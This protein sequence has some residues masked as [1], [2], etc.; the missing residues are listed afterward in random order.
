M[1]NEFF[2]KKKFPV[3]ENE[4]E[5]L[6]ALSSYNIL[7]TFPDEDL[8]S[9]TL[10]AS[11]ICRTPI[12]LISLIDDKRQWFKSRVGFEVKELPREMSICQFTIMQESIY[13][14]PDTTKNS[15]FAENPLVTAKNGIRFY[16]G[17][18]LKDPNGFR[19]GT[20]CV[21][22]RQP[23][24][25]DDEQKESLELLAKEVVTHLLMRKQNDELR[26]SKETL[27]RFFDLTLDFMCIANVNGFFLKI[28]STFSSVLGYNEKELLGKPFLEFVHPDDVEV[29]LKEVEKLSRGELTIQ[30]ENR[31]RQI[32]GNYIWLSWNVKPE[33]ESGLLYATARNITESKLAEELYHKNLL[34]QKEKEIAERSGQMKEEFLANMSHEIRTP[35]NAIIGLSGL[36][37]KKGV[38]RGKEL[39]YIQTINLNSSNLFQ[40]VDNI[41]DFT[42]IESGNFDKRTTEFNIKQVIEDSARSLELT[43][44]EKGLKLLT[45]IGSEVPDAVIGHPEKLGQALLNL[46]SNSIKF[47]SAGEVNVEAKLITLNPNSAVVKFTVSDTGLGIPKEKLEDVFQP[48]V[49]VNSSFTRIHGGTG[50]GLAITRKLVEIQG[51]EIHLQSEVGKGSQFYFTLLFP[52]NEKAKDSKTKGEITELHVAR[53]GMRILIVEDNPF[54]QMVAID[55]LQ[56][57]SSSI[58]TDVAENGK[59]AIEKLKTNKYDLVLMD[60]QMPEM[61]GHTATKIIRNELEESLRYIPIIAMTAHASV[62]EI[63]SCF[64]DGMNEYISKPF[65]PETLFKKI[66][67]VLNELAV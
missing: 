29:T 18:P 52:Y 50:L 42:Q 21:I 38:L 56:D 37:L 2:D 33:P 47:T 5:R 48:F 60:I 51:G 43:A 17:A 32:N 3:P 6:Q 46:I 12:A 11:R 44:T 57:W 14:V 20:L 19:L 40:L 64:Q 65:V 41:L 31:Y 67:K 54:N 9:I 45:K 59:V 39:E 35:L 49:Q 53:E 63:E 4:K 7:D 30:F 61:D 34:L 28:S 62:K 27:Q 55:T 10:L 25:L 16:A 22:D 13:E 1:K 66:N 36:L 26:K 24:I 8:D 15:D 58:F 23:R